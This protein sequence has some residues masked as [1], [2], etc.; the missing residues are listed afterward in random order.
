M[1]FLTLA[2]GVARFAAPKVR[3]LPE[4]HPRETHGR[5]RLQIAQGEGLPGGMADDVPPPL[6]PTSWPHPLAP[7]LGKRL[8]N[9]SAKLRG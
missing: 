5:F 6:G 2:H 7:P 8:T 4:G 3:V 9:A 1:S